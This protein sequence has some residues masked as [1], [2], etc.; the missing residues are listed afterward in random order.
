[1]ILGKV[2]FGKDKATKY[3]V[4]QL[5]GSSANEIEVNELLSTNV[6][7]DLLV[8]AMLGSIKLGQTQ[9]VNLIMNYIENK[10]PV[11]EVRDTKVIFNCAIKSHNWELLDLIDKKFSVIDTLNDKVY[12]R[13]SSKGKVEDLGIIPMAID[14]M[15]GIKDDYIGNPL[16]FSL[17]NFNVEALELLLDRCQNI[18]PTVVENAFVESCVLENSNAVF[19][20]IEHDKTREIL[21]NSKII[22]L[23]LN[24]EKQL[25]EI[26]QKANS[27]LAMMSLKDELPINNSIVDKPKLKM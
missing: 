11:F 8:Y 25:Y 20:L 1:M 5:F 24:E 14:A 3:G 6:N 17:T 16:L 12:V 26:K 18:N 23:F 21:T 10:N 22:N 27:S 15:Q 9:Y 4:Y 19:Y 13:V 2:L 7:S